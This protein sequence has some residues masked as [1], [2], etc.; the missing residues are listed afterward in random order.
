MEQVIPIRSQSSPQKPL[1]NINIV[2]FIKNDIALAESRTALQ[3]SC[4][5]CHTAHREQLPDKTSEIK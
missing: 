1:A 4:S 5:G 3:R 2:Q